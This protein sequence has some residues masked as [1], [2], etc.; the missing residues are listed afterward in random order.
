M[1]IPKKVADPFKESVKEEIGR[2]RDKSKTCTVS[3]TN[4]E[5]EMQALPHDHDQSR[6]KYAGIGS[7][8]NI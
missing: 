4:L 1:K 8:I 3:M 5:I 2:Q 6:N 7:M